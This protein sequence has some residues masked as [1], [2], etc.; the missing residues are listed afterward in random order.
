MK[1]SLGE[2]SEVM[3]EWS[4]LLRTQQVSNLNLGY[5]KDF[6]GLLDFRSEPESAKRKKR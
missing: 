1:T 4:E 6:R 5:L 3:V 2:P